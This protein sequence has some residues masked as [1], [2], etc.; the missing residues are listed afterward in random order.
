MH[1]C[2]LQIKFYLG[3]NE[4]CSL[5][6]STSDSSKRLLQRGSGGRS[7]YGFWWR[8]S[9]YN[10]ALISHKVFCWSW[11]ADVSMKGFS[12]FLD[13]R[14]WRTDSSEK[15]LMLGK[16]EGRRRRGW[17]RMRWLDGIPDSVDMSLSKLRELV[18]GREAWRAA[19]HG[20]AKSRT[21]LSDWAELNLETR[22]CKDWDHEIGFWKYL[23]IQNLFHQF[24][25]STKCLILHLEA[26]LGL[27]DVQ[28]LQ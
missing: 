15:T 8:G 3:Q 23:T 14:M 5:G 18:M 9:S 20:V 11:G 27:V 4:E 1:K 19:I 28:Q 26:P 22:R 12:A 6:D 16:I 17:Q 21:R 24:P 13:T 2:E 10:Q 25:W 7:I